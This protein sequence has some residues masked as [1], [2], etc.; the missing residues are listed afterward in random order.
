VRPRAAYALG[1]I[2]WWARLASR[3]PR[4]A[5][6]LTHAPVISPLVKRLGG[7]A[8]KRPAPVFAQETF[9]RWFRSRGIRNREG[10]PVVLWPD[11]FT[12]FFHTDAAKATVEVLEAA[13]HRVLIPDRPLCCGRPLYDYGMLDT[14]KRLLGQILQSL[15]PYIRAGVPVIGVEPSCLVAFRDE[16]PNL[17]PDD[18]DARR[19]AQQ[20]FLM[21]EFLVERK[22][23]DPPKLHRKA[24]VH[25]HCHH[26]VIVGFESDRKLLERMELD[27]EILDSGCCGLA[28]SFGYEA[29]EKYE[30]AQKAGERV[31]LPAVRGAT[32]DTLII[33]D[34]F[35][36]R[37]QVDHNT[38]RRALHV[39][40]VLRLAMREGSTGPSTRRPEDAIEGFKEAAPR[41]H[42]TAWIAAGIIGAG[43]AGL[44]VRRA[45]SA[46]S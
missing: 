27:F 45:W 40:E 14:A 46:R 11:T 30:V 43:L 16:L 13:G 5:N 26:K 8:P 24:V 2:Y 38:D 10:P 41:N 19:L 31:L 25:A 28:G 7:L 20:S 9:V 23:W 6:L 1:L 39:A 4:V 34:G 29:G 44:G 18:E 3:V 37:S 12:N 32:P 33:T 15:R 36:C 35:S 22:D 21:S 17:L 42:R